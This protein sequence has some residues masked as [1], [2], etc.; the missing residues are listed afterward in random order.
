VLK[1][2]DGPYFLFHGIKSFIK[3]KKDHIAGLGD[4]A[5]F[6]IVSGRRDV[7]DEQELGIGKLWWTSFYIGCLENKDEVCR[8]NAKPRFRIIDVVD[9]H[10]ISKENILFLSRHGYFQRMLFDKS[11]TEFDVGFEYGRQ[12]QPAE[13]FKRPFLIEL[14]GAGFDKPA[15]ARYFA[16]RFPRVLKIHNDR[17]FKETVSFE[18]LQE[19]ASRYRAEPEKSE[20]EEMH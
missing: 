20:R 4:I 19:I 6:V 9:R 7:R 11:I 5:D 15:N 2:C 14:M 3:L 18:E 16:L 8:F 13:L 12:L 10:G 17:S 1:G